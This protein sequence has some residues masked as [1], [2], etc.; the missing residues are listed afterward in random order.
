MSV[1]DRCGSREHTLGVDGI[2]ITLCGRCWNNGDPKALAEEVGRLKGLDVGQVEHLYHELVMTF[3][4]P[5]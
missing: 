4:S 5:S 2:D 1:C 3:G